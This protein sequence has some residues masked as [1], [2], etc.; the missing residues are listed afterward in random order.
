MIILQLALAFVFTP[1]D[2]VHVY[3]DA[4]GYAALNF[5]LYNNGYFNATYSLLVRRNHA[6]SDLSFQMCFQGHCMPGDSQAISVDAGA[7]DTITLDFVGGNETGP[8]DI[9]YLVYDQHEPNDRDSVNI[10]GGVPVMEEQDKRTVFFDGKFI[11]GTG[12]KRVIL[13]GPDGRKLFDKNV[14]NRRVY[15]GN[16]KRGVYFA[17]VYFDDRIKLLKIA[18]E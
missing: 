10:T 18:K 7:R 14:Q 6:P 1:L 3:I 15:L 17:K 12:L 8:I 2:S 11:R 4:N 13:Y 16:V 9:Y 5:E